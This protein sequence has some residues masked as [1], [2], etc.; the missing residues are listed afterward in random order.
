MGNWNLAEAGTAFPLNWDCSTP[1]PYALQNCVPHDIH[2]HLG[3]A[4][5]RINEK[6]RIQE[7]YLKPLHIPFS[8]R[9]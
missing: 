1:N 7:D 5:S 8:E 4:S 9:M 2:G 6:A 3:C